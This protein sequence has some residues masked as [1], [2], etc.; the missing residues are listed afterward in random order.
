MLPIATLTRVL[1]LALLATTP[2]APQAQGVTDQVRTWF[3]TEYAPLWRDLGQLDPAR[4]T[5]FWA[6]DFRDHPID[7]ESSLWPN[8]TERWQRRLQSYKSEG[9]RGS[10]VLVVQVEA[11]SGRAALIRTVWRDLGP[12]GPIEGLYCGTFIAGRFGQ[13][14]KFTNYFTVECSSK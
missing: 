5:P 2:V 1:I 10:T 13:D 14:W 3:M 12:D 7:T 4:L 9:L 11:I 6:D 8:T